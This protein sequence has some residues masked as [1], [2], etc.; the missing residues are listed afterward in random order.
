MFLSP[1][2]V[3]SSSY[4]SFI[5]R[6]LAVLLLSLPSC[7]RACI[8]LCLAAFLVFPT[9]S[10]PLS[11]PLS[12]PTP[13]HSTT[14]ISLSPRDLRP[15]VMLN[16]SC[17]TLNIFVLISSQ[18]SCTLSTGLTLSNTVSLNFILGN[19]SSFNLHHFIIGVFCS[20]VQRFLPSLLILMCQFRYP[21]TIT[22]SPSCVTLSS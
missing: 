8:Y 10:L 9:S 5:A 13:Y 2:G 16:T 18:Q 3:S 11:Y 19:V 20:G 22:L 21:P 14:I 4:N 7:L 6:A 17:P 12:P 1:S 15:A